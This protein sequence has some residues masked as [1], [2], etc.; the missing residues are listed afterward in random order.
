MF[1]ACELEGCNSHHWQ[2]VDEFVSEH[3]EV[4]N[5]IVSSIN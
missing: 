2:R 5:P 3:A 1:L 4:M